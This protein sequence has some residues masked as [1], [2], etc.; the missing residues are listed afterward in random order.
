MSNVASGGINAGKTAASGGSTTE[1]GFNTAAGLGHTLSAA[2]LVLSTSNGLSTLNDQL[3]HESNFD[4]TGDIR[5]YLK[6][7]YWVN[8]PGLNK[9]DATRSMQTMLQTMA[10]NWVYRQQPVFIMGGGDC[11]ADPN[12]PPVVAGDDVP[13]VWCDA[14]N[15]AWLLYAWQPNQNQ[16]DPHGPEKFGT[17]TWPW[18][19]DRLGAPSLMKQKVFTHKMLSLLANGTDPAKDGAAMEGL[20]TIPVCDL[21]GNGEVVVPRLGS[22][23]TDCNVQCADTEFVNKANLN[24]TGFTVAGRLSCDTNKAVSVE[25]I[26]VQDGLWKSLQQGSGA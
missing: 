14:D 26:S 7:G 8:F 23:F 11:S 2:V 25:E 13:F 6:D 3:M 9:V 10:I 21:S 16:W 18:G 17:A 15:K 20:W 4:N 5:I 24:D 22:A 19:S 12:A 1:F